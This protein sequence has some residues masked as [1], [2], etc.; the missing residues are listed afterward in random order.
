MNSLLKMK[1]F[2]QML[3]GMLSKEKTKI[4]IK[5]K[6]NQKFSI[7]IKQKINQIK[8]QQEQAPTVEEELV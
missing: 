1:E 2:N 3:T 6:L 5:N 8:S 4:F 7:A